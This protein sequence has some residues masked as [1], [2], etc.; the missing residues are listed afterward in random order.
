MGTLNMA[1]P[2]HWQWLA[3][4]AMN[5]A[6]LGLTAGGLKITAVG[7]A[8]DQGTHWEAAT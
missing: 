4:R 7:A 2:G 3:M 6:E 8:L 1:E 5:A